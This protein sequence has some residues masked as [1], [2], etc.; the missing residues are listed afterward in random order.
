[1]WTLGS[2]TST[3][4]LAIPPSTLDALPPFALQSLPPSTISRLPPSTIQRLL[5][6]TVDCLHRTRTKHELSVSELLL[7]RTHRQLRRV[8]QAD[9]F[10]QEVERDVQN[11]QRLQRELGEAQTDERARILKRAVK[12]AEDVLQEARDTLARFHSDPQRVVEERR[13]ALKRKRD[14][15]HAEANA[16]R[17]ALGLPPL[18]VPR[19]RQEQSEQSS[20]SS[21]TSWDTSAARSLHK[22]RPLSYVS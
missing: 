21:P 10:A 3:T 1:M 5:P 16:Y 12:M 6:S 22:H 11:V 7:V 14:K 18:S 17:K 8:E 13:K 19:D 20:V 4:M 9:Y 15:H 2:L